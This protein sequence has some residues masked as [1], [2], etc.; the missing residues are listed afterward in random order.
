[1]LN[2]LPKSDCIFCPAGDMR[3]SFCIQRKHIARKVGNPRLLQ[4][5]FHTFR[6][7]KGTMEYHKTRDPFYAKEI[8]GHKSIQSTQVYIYIDRALLQNTPPDEF[9]VRVAKTLEEI[10][11]LLEAGFEY[12]LQKDYLAC[13]RKQK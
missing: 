13:F 1:M 9:H 11:Q 6:D 2:N 4:I 10:T 12:V 5:H 7:W 8:L 3:F